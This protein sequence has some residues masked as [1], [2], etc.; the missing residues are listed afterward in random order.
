MKVVTQ[1]SPLQII[2]LYSS[3]DSVENVIVR[4]LCVVYSWECQQFERP[5]KQFSIPCK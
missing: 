2:N 3:V 1:R 5:L 4:N